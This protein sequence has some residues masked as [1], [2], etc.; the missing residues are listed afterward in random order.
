MERLPF[1]NRRIVKVAFFIL[2]LHLAAGFETATGTELVYY[3]I[4]VASFASLKNTNEFVN[5]LKNKGKIVF[6]KEADVPGKGLFYRVY[7][8]KYDD[9]AEAEAFWKNLK[10]EGAVSYHGI[11]RFKEIIEPVKIDEDLFPKKDK[12]LAAIVP[13]KPSEMKEPPAVSKGPRF[14]DNKNGT[15]TD[16]RTNLMWTKNGWRL[17]FFS[18]VTWWE[19]EKKCQE[20][21]LGGFGNWRLPT[22]AEWKTLIDTNQQYPA[23]IDPNPFENIIVHMPYWSQTDFMYSSKYAYHAKRPL[24]AYVVTLYVG[25]INHQ[26]KSEKAFIFPVRVVR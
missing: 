3:S 7:I 22:I 25:S 9:L 11:H 5:S 18:A 16:T 21:K 8:G 14:I 2:F 19:A 15:I 6:W 12:S 23:L 10:Q 4:H 20:F 1:P 17:D 26:N 13:E 24:Q